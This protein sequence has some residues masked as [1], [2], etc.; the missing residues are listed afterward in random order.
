MRQQREEL[1]KP[2]KRIM[3]MDQVSARHFFLPATQKSRVP[4]TDRR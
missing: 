3:E 1:G 2:V 4:Y